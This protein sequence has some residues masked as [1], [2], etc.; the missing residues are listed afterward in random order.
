MKRI[1]IISF[2]LIILSLGFMSL[3]AQEVQ[4]PSLYGIAKMT[5]RISSFELAKRYYGDFL[6]FSRA[7]SYPSGLGKVESYKVNDRQYIE[8]VEDKEAASKNRII[9][10]SFETD[11][12]SQMKDYLLSKGILLVKDLYTDGAGNRVLLINDPAGVPIEFIQYTS[13]SLHVKSKGKHLSSKRISTRIH[14]VGLYSKALEDEP[15]FYTRILEFKR[16]FR[17]PADEKEAPRILYFRIP[18]SAEMIEHYPTTDINFT[19]PCFVTMDIQ[20]TFST[21]R[22][23]KKDEAL[24]PPSIGMGK[25][26]LLNLWTADGTKVEFTEPYV[27]VF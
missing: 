3:N 20:E 5:Y 21:L 26:W 14:H 11:N 16:V 15:F 7:F 4:R 6:G 25:R 9:S 17:F 13:N 12:V 19:H 8:F 18:E 27:S 10:V 22:E 1:S 24:P 2:L 23:R